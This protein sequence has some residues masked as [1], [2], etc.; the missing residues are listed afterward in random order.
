MNLEIRMPKKCRVVH[1]FVHTV[2]ALYEKDSTFSLSL[3]TLENSGWS[4]Q[5]NDIL[6]NDL[7]L[8]Y[9]HGIEDWI[10]IKTEKDGLFW[11]GDLH[12]VK[13]L[14]DCFNCAVHHQRLF[15]GHYE[16]E[17]DT[18]DWYMTWLHALYIVDSQ[19]F[20]FY[21]LRCCF[22]DGFWEV[23]IDYD[24]THLA[25]YGVVFGK[26]EEFDYSYSRDKTYLAK[27][28]VLELEQLL[29]VFCENV[30]ITRYNS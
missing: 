29:A 8:F 4:I 19:W 6:V 11:A 18:L 28:S 9:D 13:L 7:A 27:V 14:L 25:S 26:T 22:R 12:S 24:W 3:E 16:N 15:R 10:S 20:T 17:N 30:E 21:G 1:D 23:S 5:T 2:K